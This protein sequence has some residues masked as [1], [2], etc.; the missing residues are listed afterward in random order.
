MDHV[1]GP[2]VRRDIGQLVRMTTPAQ[3]AQSL[4][5]Q[6]HLLAD[7]DLVFASWGCPRFDES[8]LAAAPRL[9][10]VFY[11]AGTIKSLVTDAFWRRDI[12]ITTARSANAVPVSEY[13]LAAILF[14][15]KHGWH[16]ILRARRDSRSPHL[17]NIPGCL[18]STVGLVSLGAVGCL[19]R[20]RLRPFDLRVVAYDPCLDATRASAMDVTLVGLEE[21]FRVSDVVSIHAPSLETTRGMITGDLIASMKP[22]ATLIN[23]AR[24]AVVHEAELLAVAERRPDLQFVLDVTDPE[25]PVAGSSIFTLPNVVYTPH[26]AGSRDRECRRMG[27]LM[28]E[29]LKRYLAGQPL[30][31][32]V[33]RDMERHMA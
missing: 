27:A 33:T 23:T 32:V 4:A 6:M 17:D 10:A 2:D 22:G 9:K 8:F 13:T 5:G 31:W 15:L 29:E 28:L 24:G 7:V 1:Y 11:A 18:G 25:P 26:I 3:S 21:L 19:V 14:S 20:E 16:A 30:Q 12:V